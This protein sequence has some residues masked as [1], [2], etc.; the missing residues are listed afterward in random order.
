MPYIPEPQN[1]EWQRSDSLDIDT[2]A[3]LVVDILGGD[4]G[5]IPE[6]QDMADNAAKI[7]SAAH[8]ADIPV[9]FACDAHI[10]GLDFEI[11]LWGNHGIAGTEAAKPLSSLGV[12]KSD[13]IIPKRRYD[14]FFETDLDLTL[15]ELGVDT[16]IVI[17][18]DTNICVQQTLAGAYYR[19]Y[20]TIVP[21]DATATFLVGTQEAGL[22]YFTRCFDTRVVDTE[23]V[24]DYLRK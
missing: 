7:V 23:A 20:K 24:L 12:E 17:G 8:A 16:L 10:E 9:L 19:T 5:A 11:S 1:T 2:C 14:S 6:L 18:C 22:E 13:Y 21:A 3:L 4:D 15:R